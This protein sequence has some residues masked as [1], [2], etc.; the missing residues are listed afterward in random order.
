MEKNLILMTINRRIVCL[1]TI[2]LD[3]FASY[4]ELGARWSAIFFTT[5][6]NLGKLPTPLLKSWKKRMY[7]L[8]CSDK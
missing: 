5:W 2:A 4:E 8:K 1:K 7:K 6:R 3:K